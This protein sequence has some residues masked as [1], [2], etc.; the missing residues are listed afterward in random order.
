MSGGYKRDSSAITVI[1]SKSTR[2]TATMNCN[3]ISTT[4]LARVI[5]E[6]VSKYMKNAVVNI[7]R[8]GGYGASVLSKLITTS[9]KP[10]LFYEIKDRVIEERFN[11]T[12]SLR[13]TQKTKVYGLDSTRDTREL[14]IQILRERMDYHKDKF[15]CPIIYQELEGMEVKKDGRVEHSSNTHD[16]QVFSYLM[17]LYVW[18]YG[19]DLAERYGIQKSTIKTD[20]DLDEAVVTI[21][22]KYADIIEEIENLDNEEIQEQLE[23][24]KSDKTKLYEEWLR[25]EFIKDEAAMQKII[26]TKIGR[27]AYIRQFHVHPDD[28][29]EGIVKLPVSAFDMSNMDEE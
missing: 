25:E 21:D 22:E 23:I 16:D 13:K 8:N 12:K 26:N 7:E 1:D 18:Y 2:V 3:Y 29:N 4:D 14:L 6:I 9:I 11:G 17:A 19:S 28:I 5:Y 24:L 27:E 15:I 20:Q 10:N